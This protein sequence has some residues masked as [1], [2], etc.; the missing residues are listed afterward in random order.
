[1]KKLT[2]EI[3]AILAISFV[4]GIINNSLSHNRI[5]WIGSWPTLSDSE[6]DSTWDCLSCEEGDPPFLSLAEASAL[7]QNPEVLF[8]DARYPEEY[9]RGHIERAMLLPIEAEDD[10][11]EAYWREVEPLLRKDTYIVTYCSGA[12]CE[13]SLFLARYLRDEMGYDSVKIFFGG[14]RRWEDAGLPAVYSDQEHGE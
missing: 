1:V 4:A 5:A 7:Y 11:Y 12:E 14:W 2:I 6:D 3:V 10:E 9:E 13:S 8:L